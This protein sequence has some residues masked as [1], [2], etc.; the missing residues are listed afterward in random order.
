MQLGFSVWWMHRRKL[1]GS[2][3][4]CCTIKGMEQVRFH[5]KD[6]KVQIRGNV[7]AEEIAS[8][9]RSLVRKYYWH[10]YLLGRISHVCS[11]LLCIE[12][13][14]G[15]GFSHLCSML[16]QI[17]QNCKVFGFSTLYSSCS[18]VLILR[19]ATKCALPKLTPW[20]F[21]DHEYMARFVFQYL[22][23]VG[24]HEA[25]CLARILWAIDLKLR[26]SPRSEEVWYGHLETGDPVGYIIVCMWKR[27]RIV[28]LWV[29][30]VCYEHF[31]MLCQI[32]SKST[33]FDKGECAWKDVCVRPMRSCYW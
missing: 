26:K 5:W 1:L 31:A 4:R 29:S 30:W 24:G 33:S 22:Y 21:V 3:R 25:I 20:F 15:W 13:D 28:F 11:L 12:K 17:L 8:S 18:Q 16:T 6:G 19:T 23:R 10:I 27:I 14:H 2:I 7:G 9:A 32:H